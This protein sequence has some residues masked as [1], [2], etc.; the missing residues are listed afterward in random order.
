M[1]PNAVL[2]INTGSSSVRLDLLDPAD[3]S[4]PARRSV[5]LEGAGMSDARARIGEVAAGASLVAHRVVHGGHRFTSAAV[6]DDAVEAG[7]AALVTLAPLHNEPALRWI[8]AARE[9]TGPA[10]PHVAVFDTSFFA[11]LPAAA[12]TYAVDRK[13]ARAHGLRRMG[14]HGL[15]HQSMWRQWAASR[16]AMAGAGRAITFQLGA[17]CSAAAIA[18]GR[19]LDTSMGFTP[20]EG[21]VMAT[22][23]GDIDPGVLLHLLREGR[24]DETSLDRMLSHESGLAGMAGEGDMRA[25]LARNDD[26]ARAA[27]DV[28]VHRARR[29][30]GGYLAVLRGADAV[31]FGGG[32]G[33]GSAHIRARIVEGMEFAGIVLDEA[34]NARDAGTPRRI[35][36]TNSLVDIFVARVDEAAVMAEEAI[37]ALRTFQGKDTS[38]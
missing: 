32:V 19:P 3:P 10:T 8:R 15:A 22:R 12:S 6:I 20:L 24:M 35:S 1:S 27:I 30:L 4:G 9:C 16:P 13:V 31:V 33:E 17:G 26:D 11:A 34:Q 21:L 28:Y 7:I 37:A 2:A 29:Y 5:R 25:L 38:P 14:F 36:A 18:G 23:G